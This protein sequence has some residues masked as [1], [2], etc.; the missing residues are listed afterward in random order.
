MKSPATKLLLWK[1]DFLS[2][3]SER[4][5]EIL[6]HLILLIL[7]VGLGVYVGTQIGAKEEPF[8]VFARIFRSDYA[9]FYYILR[10]LL[11]FSIFAVIAA[12]S[13]F[14]PCYPLY[15][16]F[17]LF[18]FGKHFGELACLAFL[19]DAVATALPTVLITAIPLLIIGGGLLIRIALLASNFRLCNGGF[20][21]A[22]TLKRAGYI[23]FCSIVIYA[24]LLTIVYL[25]FCGLFYLL[26]TA[27]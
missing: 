8:G 17:S 6:L 19:S 13:Y 1:T 18:F 5:K 16:T 9:P 20:L 3:F 26:I 4:K 22:N 21:R 23:L 15:P 12:L 2:A 24:T 7:G 25:L 11:R 27:L 14:L 10:E